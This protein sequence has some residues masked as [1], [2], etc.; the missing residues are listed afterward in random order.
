MLTIMQSGAKPV[1]G[2]HVH[3][4]PR[5]HALCAVLEVGPGSLFDTILLLVSVGPYC[6]A[7]K[8]VTVL[9]VRFTSPQLI[10]QDELLGSRQ[11]L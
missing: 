1:R 7:G 3:P 8:A 4:E 10:L 11:Q 5:T 9:S 2:G 6:S